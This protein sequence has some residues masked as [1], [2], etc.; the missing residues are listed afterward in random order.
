[1]CEQVM[2]LYNLELN[3]IKKIELNIKSL[4]SKLE[5]LKNKKREKIFSNISRTK[6]EYETWKKLKYNI[7][8]N[9]PEYIKKNEEELEIR[10]NIQ[11]PILFE[12]KYK[13]IENLI[14]NP[15]IK[16]IYHE[17]NNFNLE[18]IFINEEIIIDE[19]IIKFSEKYTDISKSELHYGFDHDWD[20]LESELGP[21]GKIIPS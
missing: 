17:L 6:N 5:R 1:M 20:Y 3:K 21:D 18:E 8:K 13:Y 19:K 11:I 10:D 12:A 2:D 4:N 9:N 7:P 14:N 16:Q 15:H